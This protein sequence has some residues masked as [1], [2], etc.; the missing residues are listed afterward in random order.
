M[1]PGATPT[2]TFKV[3][4]DTDIITALRITYK[5]GNNIVLQ[6]ELKDCTLLAGEIECKLSQKDTLAFSDSGMV[7]VQMKIRT[8][9]NDVLVSKIKTV[10][11]QSVLDKEVI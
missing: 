2:H 4:M 3:P 11:V 10:P 9:G 5:Q 6:K 7:Y 8:T 1:I